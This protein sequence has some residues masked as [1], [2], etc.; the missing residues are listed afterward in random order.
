[1]D[2][3]IDSGCVYVTS[4][5]SEAEER[6]HPPTDAEGLEAIILDNRTSNG[7]YYSPEITW[8]LE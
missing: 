5:I 3:P 4:A 2:N 1:M 8:S 7:D 6:P